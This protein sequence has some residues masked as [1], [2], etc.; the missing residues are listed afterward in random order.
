MA[1]DQALAKR[2]D[3]AVDAALAEGRLVG[4]TVMVSRDGEVVYQRHAGLADRDAGRPV[5]QDT[6]FRYASLTKPMV[7]AAALALVEDGTIALDAA[8]TDWL[9]GFR[10]KLADGREPTIAI[11][12]LMTH[13]S[14]LTYDFMEPPERGYEAS[15]ISNGFDRVGVSMDEN[16][17]KIVAWP[18]NF[19][20][21]S[22][23]N[24]SVST[25]VLGAVLA[26]A[27]GKALSDVVR[28]KVTG[29]LGLV[30]T[31]FKVT[32]PGR[33]AVAYAN[34]ETGPVKMADGHEVPFLASPLRYAPSRALSGESFESGGAGMVGRADDYVKFLETLRT[35]G[36]AIL[37]PAS[38]AL[39]STNAT[40]DILVTAAG[41][42]YGFS[43]GAA[44]LGDPSATMLPTPQTA[45]T[46]NWGGVYGGS[47]FVDPS[48]ALVVVTLTNTAIEGMAGVLPGTVRD[49][50]YAS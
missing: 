27:A 49:A 16:L 17:A 50:V 35:G 37:K 26:K 15:G 3:A 13:T 19:A 22:A 24:Y 8:V 18:L 46:W 33:L 29:P 7:S 10:P 1:Q 38:A 45:G 32:D 25:D 23:W 43:L 42:G 40:G 9:P 41:P 48:K 30:D 14:G 5:A 12:H 47:W 20:P 4:G 11:R 36:G 21:G 39:M 28:E 31:G 44:V 34:S 2:I 6:I